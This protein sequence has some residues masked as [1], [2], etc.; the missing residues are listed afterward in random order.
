MKNNDSTLIKRLIGMTRNMDEREEQVVN[1]K[2]ALNFA[3]TYWIAT[4]FMVIS[5]FSDAYLN[6]LSF[7]SILL[8]LLVLTM[9]VLSMVSL[10][11]QGITYQ[12]VESKADYQ[13]ALKKLKIQCLN[14]FIFFLI[15]SFILNIAF[16]ILVKHTFIVSW[17]ALLQ[18]LMAGII[19]GFASYFVAKSKIHIEDE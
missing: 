12:H 10:K 13:R 7:G 6:T 15:F 1:S 19:F 11:G 2:L 5:V 14:A 3:I 8:L 4:L 18:S 16:E 9:S 17:N